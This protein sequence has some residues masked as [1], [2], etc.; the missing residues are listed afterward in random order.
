MRFV[1]EIMK[2]DE[3][4]MWEKIEGKFVE[5]DGFTMKPWLEWGFKKIA[6]FDPTNGDHVDMARTC[7]EMEKE[8][9]EDEEK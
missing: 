1:D 4:G 9:E 3:G 6:D 5:H 7:C 2:D 8:D